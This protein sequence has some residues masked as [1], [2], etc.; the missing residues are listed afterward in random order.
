MTAV[1]VIALI[2]FF[3]MLDLVV[4]RFERPA[5]AVLEVPALAHATVPDF[6]VPVNL[7]MHRGHTWARIMENSNVRVGVDDFIRKLAGGLEN[8]R[9][10]AEGV[11]I[12]KGERAISIQVGGHSLGLP[13]PVNGTVRAVNTGIAKLNGGDIYS[14]GWMLEL[15]PSTLANDLVGLYIADSAIEW[16]KE[17]TSR[18]REFIALSLQPASAF[19]GG[20][21][22]EGV[23]VK[24]QDKD[25]IKFNERFIES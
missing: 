8:V 7:F 9:L 25:W 23:L 15:E 16:M 20:M 3:V 1:L 12:V 18:L 21:P 2:L 14:D 6:P 17:E 22:V 24:L 13:V 11:K 5:E 19:D 4:Q 10:P